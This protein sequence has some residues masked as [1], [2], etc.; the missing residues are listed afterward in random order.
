MLWKSHLCWVVV[1]KEVK[2]VVDAEPPFRLFAGHHL[3]QGA[4]VHDHGVGGVTDELGD[5]QFMAKTWRA[6]S[7]AE[8]GPF[9]TSGLADS[10]GSELQ[11]QCLWETLYDG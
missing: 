5:N 10:R 2:D 7:G 6:S 1:G 8:S 11:W 9:L 3:G 4:D